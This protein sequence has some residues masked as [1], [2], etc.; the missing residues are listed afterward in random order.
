MSEAKKMVCVQVDLG[1]MVYCA[2][3]DWETKVLELLT[4]PQYARDNMTEQIMDPDGPAPDGYSQ[5]FDTARD[6]AIELD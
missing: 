5:Y 1:C 4:D 2:E 6:A 3:E